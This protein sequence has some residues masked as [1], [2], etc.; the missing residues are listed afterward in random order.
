M[1]NSNLISIGETAVKRD[2]LQDVSGDF[3]WPLQFLDDE[4]S[5]PIDVSDDTFAFTVYDTDGTTTL[6]SGTISLIND[7]TVQVAIDLDDYEGTVGCKY[8]Y[9]LLQTTASGLRKPL[10]RGKFMLTK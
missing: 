4:T 2:I 6:M 5:E 1:A 10:F 9:L 7:S 3:R 8:E